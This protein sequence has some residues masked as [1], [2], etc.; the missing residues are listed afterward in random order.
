LLDVQALRSATDEV[1]LRRF[2]ASNDEAAFRVI[3][4]RHGPMVLGVCRRALRCAHDAEDAF[5]ATFLVFSRRASSIRNTASLGSWLH[6]V[7]MR[8][9]MKLRRERTRRQR[10]EQSVQKAATENAIEKLTWSEVKTGMDEELQ[11]LPDHYRSVLVLC[12]LE[13]QTR[14]EAA[15]QLGLTHS[16]L[17]GR[18]ERGR[19]LLA[20]RLSKRGLTLS[21]AF[22]PIALCPSAMLAMVRAA[23]LFAEQQSIGTLVAPSVLALT[24]ETLKGMT[25]SKMKLATAALICSAMLAVGVGFTTAQTPGEKG[26]KSANIPRSTHVASPDVTKETDNLKNT[27]LALDKH[28][29]EASAKGDWQERQKFLADDLVSISILGKYGKADAAASDKL[30][31]CSDWTIHDPEVVRVSPDVAMLTYRYDCKIVTQE[32]QL[33]ETR[34]DYRVVYTWAFRNG[35]WVIVFC[36]DDHGR[37]TKAGSVTALDEFYDLGSRFPAAVD[38]PAVGKKSG[39]DKRPDSNTAESNLDSLKI[40]VAMAMLAVKEKQLHLDAAI[41]KKVGGTDLELLKIDLEQ[42]RLLLQEAE[43]NLSAAKAAQTPVPKT[44]GNVHK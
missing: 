23:A 29:W 34:K 33:L 8:V 27:L 6:G 38:L 3:A 42:A 44:S 32:G 21:A 24:H 11:R 19:K 2:V 31:R 26:A 13:G 14:D 20:A 39:S 7:A 15:I 10:R 43:L 22:L 30:T 28:I 16:A 17:H 37:Q 1:L 41:G 35:G 40:K 4:E 9:A 12:Y 25:M 5:Q 18:L 36:H